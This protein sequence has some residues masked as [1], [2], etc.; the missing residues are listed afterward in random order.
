MRVWRS[1]AGELFFAA[2]RITSVVQSGEKGNERRT[3]QH[4]E[5]VVEAERAKCQLPVS[6]QGVLGDIIRVS[7]HFGQ[8]TGI[9]GDFRSVPRGFSPRRYGESCF[10]I[11]K[12]GLKAA[13]GIKNAFDELLPHNLQSG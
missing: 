4:R 12:A 6:C 11:V 10:D 3:N 1:V 5:A 8:Q 2:E 9:L 7:A 13:E